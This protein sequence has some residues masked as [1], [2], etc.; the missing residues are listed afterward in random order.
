MK[1]AKLFIVLVIFITGCR[2]EDELS[3]RINAAEQFDL[4]K[5]NSAYL[6]EDTNYS[7]GSGETVNNIGDIAV[8]E[9]GNL[10][11]VNNHKKRIEV[12]GPGGEKVTNIGKPGSDPGDFQKPVYLQVVGNHLYAY[13]NSLNRGYQYSLSAYDLRNTTY[14]RSVVQSIETDSLKDAQ[15][16]SIRIMEDENYLAVFQKVYAP[17]NRQLFMYRVN[18]EGEFISDQLLSFKNRNLYVDETKNPPLIM[19][20]PYEPETLFATDSQSNLYSAFSEQFLI[21][22]RNSKGEHME[23]RY[24]PFVKQNLI[25]SDAI[26]LFTDT[27]QR[28]AIRRADLPE[29]WPALSKILIDDEDRLWVATIVNDLNT[30]RWYVM[31]PSGEPL[32]TFVLPRDLEIEVVKNG[33]V[34][35]KQYNSRAF[36]DQV[37]RYT[38]DF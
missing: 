37:K 27:F 30:Y 12:F 16:F 28:R 23:D 36:F 19:M 21:E 33:Y 25:R 20:L 18:L 10:Y 22:I 3:Q 24:Y 32:A 15:P 9:A 5:A 7:V 8:D 14:F 26:E 35:I 13:D 38:F 17:E 6:T 11:L 34:Y 4:T 1:L 2:G 29:K 31:E